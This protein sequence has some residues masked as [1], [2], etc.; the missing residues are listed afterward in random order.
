[1]EEEVEGD[2]AA[3]SD[4]QAAELEAQQRE[5]KIKK[6]MTVVKS[7]YFMLKANFPR[8]AEQMMEGEEPPLIDKHE[9]GPT[10]DFENRQQP[11]SADQQQINDLRQ[12]S[13]ASPQQA[14]IDSA[15]EALDEE[16]D[17]EQKRKE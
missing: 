12:Q 10:Y 11:P 4:L 1:M 14:I 17:S 16:E 3:A 7:K 6:L 8:Q 5:M 9:P 2:A 13:M 15:A